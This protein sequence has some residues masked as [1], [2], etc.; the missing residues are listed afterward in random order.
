MALFYAA[1]WTDMRLL[2]RRFA[3][4]TLLLSAAAN[5]VAATST[6]FY[7]GLLQH[8]ISSFHAERY[9]ESTTYL[10]LAAF[11]FVDSIES[12]Q[13][14]QVYLTLA[15]D[16]LGDAEKARDAARRV[17]AA[18]RIQRRFA[19]L[20]LPAGVAS[21]FD[22]LVT[23]LLGG[24]DAAYLK[25]PPPA[26]PAQATAQATAQTP[27]QTTVP[28][29]QP[30]IE[31]PAEKPP[32]KPPAKP[33]EK[34][35]VKPTEAPKPQPAPVRPA[36][37]PPASSA[38]KT[39]S[40]R[41]ASAL[42]VAGDRAVAAAQLPE[43]RRAYRALLESPGVTREA[44]I[45]VAEGLYRARDFEGA[46]DAFAKIGTLRRGEEPYHYYMAVASYETGN[47]AKARSEMSAAIPF[48][49]ITP[50]VARYRARIEAS[51]Q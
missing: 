16:R 18:E 30:V 15:Y 32:E 27:V 46:L 47:F 13:T 49:E 5:A 4:L 20:S 9:P 38:A 39:L 3:L 21:S 29:A 50:D 48:I 22:A 6:E 42:L 24:A 31:K 35:V 19:T 33:V 36:A 51:A 7:S 2:A 45:R 10:K 44:L 23:S 12:Y 43:A 37:Q 41:D 8:G 40:A 14:A 17:I 26:V 1:S 25:R 34:P 28:Q 11:G